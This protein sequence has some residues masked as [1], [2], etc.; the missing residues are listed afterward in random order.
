MILKNTL[1]KIILS[2]LLGVVFTLSYGQTGTVNGTVLDD[3]K[4][5]VMGATIKVKGSGLGA[6]TDM[7]GKYSIANVPTGK[8]VLQISYIGY[9]SLEQELEVT[10]GVNSATASTLKEDNKVLSEVV[11]VG[12]GTQIKKEVSSSLSEVKSDALADRPVYDFTSSLQGQAAGVDIVT[13]NGLAGATTTVRVRGTKSLTNSSEPLYVIDG[14]PIVSYDI[15][16]ADATSG[17][18]ISPMSSIDPADIESVVILKDASATAI[19]GARGA[20][21]VILVTT[22]HGKSGK[23]KV[24][25]SFNTGM[26]QAA[27]VI[28]LENGP[29]YMQS[30]YGA[31]RNDSAATM[32]ANPNGPKPA[33]T[34][35]P[36]GITAATA[37]NTN[38]LKL[39]LRT[40]HYEDVNVAVSGGDAK[41]TYYLG[42]N[43][44]DDQ[45]FMVGNAFK[46]ASFRAN[47]DHTV[48]KYFSIGF[49]SSL[50]YTFNQYVPTSTAGG[51]GAAESIMLPIYPVYNK[52]GSYFLPS[53]N[54]VAQI[55]LDKSQNNTYR[56]VSDA[57]LTV[58][59]V[60]GLTFRNDFGIDMINQL[61]NFYTAP[62]IL[63]GDSGIATD[64]RDFYFTWNLNTTLD[65]KK[66]INENN[67]IDF[68]V[69]FNPTE[70]TEKYT[71]ISQTG[72]PT[73]TFT[74]PQ[75]GTTILA[76]LAG[77]G[78][79]YSFISYLA[80][81]NYTLFKRFIFQLSGRADGSSRFAAGNRYGYF[82]AGSVAY[83]MSDEKFFNKK[84]HAMNLFKIRASVGE[85]GNAN[86]TTDFAYLSTYGATTYAGYQAITPNNLPVNNLTWETTLKADVGF[87]LSFLQGRVSATLD[88]YRENTYNMIISAYPLSPSSGFST[89][90]R[91]VGSLYNEGIE[92]QINTNNLG[93]KSPVG[94][95]T[96][97][98]IATNKNEVTNLGGVAQVAGTN[99]GNNRAILDEPVGVWDLAKYAGIDPKTG[100]TLIYDLSGNKVVATAGNTVADAVPVGRPYP[101]IFGGLNNTFTYKGFDLGVMLTFSVGNQIYDDDG[102]R[103]TGDMAFGWNQ[104]TDALNAWTTPGQNTNIPKL[105]LVQNYDINTTR[106]LYNASFLRLRNITFG[107]TIPASA[108]AK[109]KMRSLRIYV[110]GQNLA[111]ATQYKGWD[112]ETNRDNSGGITQGVSYLNSP[113]A[114]I[115]QFGFNIGF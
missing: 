11:V 112:P 93:P 9:T 31:W 95:K 6:A 55:N 109:M 90:T 3:K 110:S 89:D 47:L 12:Y 111:V 42:M 82:P 61:E 33:F 78:R 7:D 80:R 65:Y 43:F 18:N 97:L 77:T 114:R 24:D 19:Y 44:R 48:N 16:N 20:G 66:E 75:G 27:H 5:P 69:G 108:A 106:Y 41:T 54:P 21:G 81:F 37:A 86:M 2:I 30:Y 17:Y 10:E 98:N 36:Q 107:Y 91:N 59:P 76:G 79:Q 46:R 34:G 87:D 22:K 104:L 25:I 113:Q 103:Q 40:G 38:W 26:S 84:Q 68:L 49:N 92:L 85:T 63:Q 60:T 88:L 8:Q 39:L 74:Q 105:S 115:Y 67:A 51:L 100:Q 101:Y 72:F 57:Y 52:D 94:W 1:P 56:S 102:K 71:Y 4:E 32:A 14:V 29:Q 53:Q 62:T 83:V 64:R 73:T 13:D 70:T 45:S 58:T 28:S 96:T 23:T 35:Y 50:A 15:S 99:Y